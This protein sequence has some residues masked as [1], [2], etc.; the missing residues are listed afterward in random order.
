M[1]SRYIS[2][3][4]SVYTWEKKMEDVTGEKKQLRNSILAGVTRL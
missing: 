4:L 1:I 2:L 3:S